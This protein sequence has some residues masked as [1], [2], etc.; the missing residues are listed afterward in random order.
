M[1]HT[2]S[3]SQLQQQQPGSG[4]ILET[5]ESTRGQ[6]ANSFSLP[7]NKTIELIGEEFVQ[8]MKTEPE[9]VSSE[10]AVTRPS[11]VMSVTLA[12]NQE[13]QPP[14]NEPPAEQQNL[15]YCNLNDLDFGAASDN[16]SFALV[17]TTQLGET[18]ST[19]ITTNANQQLLQMVQ[20]VPG[21]QI[22]SSDKNPYS[23]VST[24]LLQ[25]GILQV[26]IS[27]SPFHHCQWDHH[28]TIYFPNQTSPYRLLYVV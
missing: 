6:P 13:E 4:H 22:T 16:S 25:G 24:I 8:R 5:V 20:A 15:V 18:P 23:A 7:S 9:E 21:L 27:P 28:R 19:S 2:A 10:A 11:V 17:S 1:D 12:N 14:V 3:P 26:L